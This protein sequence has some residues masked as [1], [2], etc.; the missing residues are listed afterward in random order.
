MQCRYCAT[1]NERERQTGRERLDV[2]TMFAWQQ[3]QQPSQALYWP[4][5]CVYLIAVLIG[6]CLQCWGACVCATQPARAVLTVSI[7]PMSHHTLVES[8]CAG[9]MQAGRGGSGW[10]S[11]V[12]QMLG[13]C[14]L[15][16]SGRLCN[17]MHKR[18]T[19]FYSRALCPVFFT[20]IHHGTYMHHSSAC[21]STAVKSAAEQGFSNSSPVALSTVYNS[22]TARQQQLHV[23]AAAVTAVAVATFSYLSTGQQLTCQDSH[24]GHFSTE[25]SAVRAPSGTYLCHRTLSVSRS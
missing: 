25:C 8:C 10:T 13:T 6:A 2:P 23:A 21:V 24:S 11:G 4:L 3:C 7:F 12:T 9:F 16:A 22:F 15:C 14:T 1:E 18:E 19:G 5:A 17:C 20:S